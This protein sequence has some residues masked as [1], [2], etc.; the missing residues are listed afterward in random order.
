MLFNASVR[1]SFFPSKYSA[2]KISICT[3]LI[4]DSFFVGKDIFLNQMLKTESEHDN[5]GLQ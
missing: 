4:P 3:I 5:L 1:E 2:D